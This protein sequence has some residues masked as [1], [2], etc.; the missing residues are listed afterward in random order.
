[1]PKTATQKP[2]G[3]LYYFDMAGRGDPPNMV[4]AYMGH[5]LQNIVIPL[6]ARPYMVTHMPGKWVPYLK[7]PSGEFMGET[8]DITKYLA[9]LASPLGR[10]LK[11]DALQDEIFKMSNEP[12]ISHAR[13]NDEDV[14]NGRPARNTV[15]PMFFESIGSFAKPNVLGGE[16]EVTIESFKKDTNEFWPALE[17]R[18]RSAVG[19]FFGGKE[20]G[21]G[22][23][24]LFA[25][26]TIVERHIQGFVL[27]VGPHFK[28]WYDATYNLPGIKEYLTNRPQWHERKY[29]CLPLY[30]LDDLK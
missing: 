7:K 10:K 28:V 27:S 3:I 20:P 26:I 6:C 8:Q 29:G 13:G 5:H 18:L 24:G 22:D 4:A 21:Y 12:P 14:K 30:T 17:K 19:P 23:I 11:T 9:E 2:C 25:V 15:N 16:K 1:M